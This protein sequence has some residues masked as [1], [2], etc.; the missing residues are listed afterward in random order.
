MIFKCLI[1][2][3]EVT[4][5]MYSPLLQQ[6]EVIKLEKRLDDSLFYLRDSPLEYSTFNPQMEPDPTIEG[7]TVKVN[8]IKVSQ[9][10]GARSVA[11][12]IVNP[13]VMSLN[14]SLVNILFNV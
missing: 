4:Y 7:G 2:G 9:T 3:V 6:I 11:M 10:P 12:Q 14:P 5:D 1:S 13:W 8:T